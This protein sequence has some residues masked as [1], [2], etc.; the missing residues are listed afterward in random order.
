MQGGTRLVVGCHDMR[1]TPLIILLAM[2]RSRINLDVSRA[3]NTHSLQTFALPHFTTHP[4][5]YTSIVPLHLQ[6]TSQTLHA[7]PFLL[8]QGVQS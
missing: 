2:F 8:H 7:R 3:T 5:F 4:G 6:V 1:T